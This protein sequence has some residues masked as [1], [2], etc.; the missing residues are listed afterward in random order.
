MK[1]N[2]DFGG[3][4][5]EAFALVRDALP[6]V[7]VYVIV[8]AMLGTVQLYF[9]GGAD[10]NFGFSRGFMLTESVV[11]QGALAILVV[12]ATG[13][14]GLV[15][16]YFYFSYLL[17]NR[18]YTIPHNRIL[19]YVGF[20]ILFGLGVGLGIVL[21]IIPGLI[22][23]TRW[24]PATGLVVGT[25]TP[26]MDSF[27]QSWDMTAGYGWPIFFG[28]VVLGIATSIVTAMVIFPVVG[29]LGQTSITYFF[30]SSLAE[31]LLGAIIGAFTIGVFYLLHDSSEQFSEVFE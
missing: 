15:V 31:N 18:G 22:L 13:I 24:S 10:S 14:A 28:Y 19:A 1:R 20:T 4:L 23:L 16:Q 30:V 9:Q 26:V 7:T 5:G 6:G 25:D 17:A 3:F 8:M 11:A 12:L 27:G 21:F 29:F 2:S